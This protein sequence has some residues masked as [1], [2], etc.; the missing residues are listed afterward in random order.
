MSPRRSAFTLIE[1]LVVIAIIAILI[2][3]LLPAVQKVREAA[4]RMKCQN[5]LKQIGLAIHNH[6]NAFAYLPPRRSSNPTCGLYVELLSYMEQDN[7]LKQ[8]DRTK[9]F[10]DPVNNAT[11]TKTLPVLRCPSNPATESFTVGI[12][13]APPLGFGPGP[14]AA[15]TDYLGTHVMIDSRLPGG[16]ILGD[17]Y[18]GL[19]DVKGLRFTEFTDGTSAT[20][21]LTEQAGRPDY[22][23][24]GVKQATNNTTY[25]NWFG[26]WAG[27]TTFQLK[28][29]GPDNVTENGNCTVNCNNDSGIYSFHTG[30]A[31]ALFADG[32]VRALRAGLDPMVMY[33]LFTRAN[34]EVLSVNDY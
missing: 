15:I 10:F 28:S 26:P 6:E 24:G 32:S 21:M 31:N 8:Y 13:T 30:L 12:L 14:N 2:G 33:A 27:Y 34:G 1:L 18:F 5:N 16:K 4:A 3:L 20:V 23:L 29:F 11:V 25:K 22:Y 19:K 7:L 17:Q 9:N